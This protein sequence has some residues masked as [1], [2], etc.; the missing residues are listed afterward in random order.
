MSFLTQAVPTLNPKTI[1]D[2]CFFLP[3]CVAMGAL[4][5]HSEVVRYGNSLSSLLRGRRGH[6]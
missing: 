5:L 6:R 4:V 3:I 2:V 1:T